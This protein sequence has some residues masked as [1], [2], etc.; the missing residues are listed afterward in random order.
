MMIGQHYIYLTRYGR[1]GFMLSFGND[2][3]HVNVKRTRD[4]LFSE[5]YNHI[6]VKR[7][8]GISI[9]IRRKAEA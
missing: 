6:P 8:A 1:G 4:E 7:F 3:T 2:R 9:S 5:R